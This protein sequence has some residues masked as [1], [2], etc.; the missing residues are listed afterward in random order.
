CFLGLFCCLWIR[1][2]NSYFCQLFACDFAWAPLVS[3]ADYLAAFD[4]VQEM[5]RAGDIYQANLTFPCE[6]PISGDPLALYATLRGR[7]RAA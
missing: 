5:I 4:N 2:L 6:L 7:Q 3:R 1:E